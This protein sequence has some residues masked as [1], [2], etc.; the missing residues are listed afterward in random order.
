LANR[1]WLS[2]PDEAVLAKGANRS[3]GVQSYCRHLRNQET[4]R[5]LEKISSQVYSKISPDL[6]TGMPAGMGLE[7]T[8]GPTMLMQQN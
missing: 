7:A 1:C 4:R 6:D 3:D 5:Q 8:P 2:E